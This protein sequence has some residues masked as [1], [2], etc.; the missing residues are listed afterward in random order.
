MIQSSLIS[1]TLRKTSARAFTCKANYNKRFQDK[2]RHAYY[3][4]PS[5]EP[6]RKAAPLREPAPYFQVFRNNFSQFYGQYNSEILKRSYRYNNK[7][8]KYFLPTW[9]ALSGLN[10]DLGTSFKIMAIVP[11]VTLY[12]RIRDKGQAP[13]IPEHYLRELVHD[14]EKLGELFKVDTTST[15]NYQ[16]EWLK[17]FPCEKKFP[18]FTNA[19]FRF[20]SSDPSMTDGTITL[21]DVESNA[22]LSLNFKTMPVRG[23]S[24]FKVG[25]PYFFYSVEGEL[26]KDGVYEKIILVD[27]KE[28]L[29]RIRPFLIF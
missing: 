27:E 29:E 28:T 20:F 25:E 5:E 8:N 26:Y 10:W 12:T 15:I 9:I 6:V 21:G 16:C 23:Y 17:E 22:V 3:N 7:F 11:M 2:F 4:A 24:L 13:E 19:L 14:N 1:K 18:E